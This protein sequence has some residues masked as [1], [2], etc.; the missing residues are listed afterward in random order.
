M[1]FA[2]RA[3]LANRRPNLYAELRDA[4]ELATKGEV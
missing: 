3:H 2:E 4:H 1:T